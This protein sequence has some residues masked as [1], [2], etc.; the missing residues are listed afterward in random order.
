LLLP[1]TA[2]AVA[3]YGLFASAA[4]L[5]VAVSLGNNETATTNRI[6]GKQKKASGGLFLPFYILIGRNSFQGG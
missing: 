4:C 5:A 1:V 6:T 2:S 3:C